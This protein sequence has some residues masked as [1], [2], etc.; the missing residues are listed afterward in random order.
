MSEWWEKASSFC[1]L[2]H[3]KNKMCLTARWLFSL[4]VTLLYKKSCGFV[5]EEFPKEIQ[6]LAKMQLPLV[7]H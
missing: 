1:F 5:S 4:Q 2:R 3:E 7:K 6:K